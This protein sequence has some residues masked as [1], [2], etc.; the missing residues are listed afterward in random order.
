MTNA[1]VY[2]GFHDYKKV[3]EHGV[4]R[5]SQ[6]I[7]ANNDYVEVLQCQLLWCCEPNGEHKLT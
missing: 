1:E 3:E 7:A 5:A 6:C 2:Q 4:S